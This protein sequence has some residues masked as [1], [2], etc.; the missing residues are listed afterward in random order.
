MKQ[1]DEDCCGESER[2]RE[3]MSKARLMI[4][5]TNIAHDVPKHEQRDALQS[6]VV[7]L[8]LSTPLDSAMVFT[9]SL[10]KLGT[11]RWQAG[12]QNNIDSNFMTVLASE[13][14]LLKH[15]QAHDAAFSSTCPR[16]FLE[17]SAG[18]GG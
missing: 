18:T 1:G 7:I 2:F 13:R 4:S 8:T 3:K 17:G 11:R 16:N 10:I 6:S 12:T 14:A 15:E 9:A 5:G